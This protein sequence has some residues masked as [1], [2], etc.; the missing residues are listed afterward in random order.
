M[1][2][3]GRI[4]IHNAL[5][6]YILYIDSSWMESENELECN[7]I[8]SIYKNIRLI[9]RTASRV[10]L[11]SSWIKRQTIN[12]VELLLKSREMS[13]HS[14][15]SRLNLLLSYMASLVKIQISSEETHVHKSVSFPMDWSQKMFSWEAIIVRNMEVKTRKRKCSLYKHNYWYQLNGWAVPSQ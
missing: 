6:I 3:K 8:L 15:I 14:H 12:S 4:I 13:L 1:N 5:D 2:R 9:C 7:A 10:S 11:Q